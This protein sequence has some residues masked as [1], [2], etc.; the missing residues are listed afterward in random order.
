M[1]AFDP[2]L[3]QAETATRAQRS[4][5]HVSEL[6]DGYYQPQPVPASARGDIHAEVVVLGSGPGGY[7]AAIQRGT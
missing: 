4:A 2:N 5:Q 6:L 1:T 3:A 7:V